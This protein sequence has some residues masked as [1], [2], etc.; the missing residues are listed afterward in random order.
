MSLYFTLWGKRRLVYIDFLTKLDSSNDETFL[1]LEST[2]S[3]LKELILADA[4]I[5]ADALPICGFKEMCP[6]G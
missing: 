5:S 4:L 2:P 3:D 1:I 6:P